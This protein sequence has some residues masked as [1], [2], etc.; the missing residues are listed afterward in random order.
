MD[1]PRFGRRL[2]RIDRRDNALRAEVRCRRLDQAGIAHGGRVDA[3][4]VRAGVEKRADVVDRGN[5]TAHRERNEHLVRDGFDHVVEEAPRF[6]AG[7]DVEK[8]ELVS[9]LLVV[10]ARDLDGIAG[11]AQVH[12]IDTFDHAA[13]SDVEAG[14]DALGEAHAALSRKRG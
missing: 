12:E 2:L 14:D 9:T 6:D 10:A 13:G 1:L 3:D 11:V 4:L 8:R 7:A 5:A